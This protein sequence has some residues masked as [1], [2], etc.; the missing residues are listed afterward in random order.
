[1]ISF[2]KNFKESFCGNLILAYNERQKID[3]PEIEISIKQPIIGKYLCIVCNSKYTR[4]VECKKRT[5]FLYCLCINCMSKMFI[6][7]EYFPVIQMMSDMLLSVFKI[8]I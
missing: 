2:N 6:K 7:K 8:N 3:L 4:V 1:M 5:E